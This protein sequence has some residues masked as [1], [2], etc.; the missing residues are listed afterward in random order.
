M[1]VEQSIIITNFAQITSIFCRRTKGE[2]MAFRSPVAS[3]AVTA[4]TTTT[5]RRSA[6]A[7]ATLSQP[8]V[9]K[10]VEAMHWLFILQYA[11]MIDRK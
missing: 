10:Q 4:A 5:S 9:D 7:I 3:C 6:L 11:H 1:V 8:G 2:P